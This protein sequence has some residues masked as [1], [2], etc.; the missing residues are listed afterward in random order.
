MP[1]SVYFNNYNSKQEQNVIED[2]IVESIKIMGFDAYYLPNDND[3]ARDLLYG[4]DP[5]KKFSSAFPL[6]M[7]L[8]SDPTD[9]IGQKDIFSKYIFLPNIKKRYILVSFNLI[10]KSIKK[11]NVIFTKLNFLFG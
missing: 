2:L 9:Y 4:E 11:M 1:T 7:Y 10:L 8:S 6:E 3:A 5:V